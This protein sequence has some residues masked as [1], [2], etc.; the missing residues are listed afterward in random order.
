LIPHQPIH[1]LESHFDWDS[2]YSDDVT[3]AMPS[4]TLDLFVIDPCGK[5]NDQ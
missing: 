4:Q 3:I 2:S 5:L 1:L